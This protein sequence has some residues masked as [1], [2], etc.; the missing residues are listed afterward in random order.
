MFGGGGGCGLE[1]DVACSDQAMQLP[2]P[3][4]DEM[5]VNL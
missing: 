2:D 4:N 3:V 1:A 5:M